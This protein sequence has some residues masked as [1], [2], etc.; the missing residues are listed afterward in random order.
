MKKQQ[1][2]LPIL[3]LAAIAY[4]GYTYWPVLGSMF[5]NREAAIVK[6]APA[7]P[8]TPAQSASSESQTAS[9]TGQAVTLEATKAPTQEELINPFALRIKVIP[10]RENIVATQ[11]VRTAEVKAVQPELQG[12]WVDASMKIAFISDQT[13]SEGGQ[14]LGWRVA[15]IEKTY[16]MLTKGG[17]Q[18][19]L[20]VEGL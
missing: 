9:V 15:R 16:V 13:V 12:I 10:K 5:P 7:T 11:Q 8:K 14:V 17:K 20:K 2:L 18:R 6:A 19:I 4:A 3:L 1:L